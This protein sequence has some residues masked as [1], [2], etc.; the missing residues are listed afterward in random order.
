MLPAKEKWVGR[1][2][3]V[4]RRFQRRPRRLAWPVGVGL[5][6]GKHMADLGADGIAVSQMLQQTAVRHRQ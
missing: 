4:P 6:Q 1:G 3:L 5:G 2:E